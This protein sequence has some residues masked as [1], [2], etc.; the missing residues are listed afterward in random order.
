MK[1]VIDL[2]EDI[3]ESIANDERYEVAVGLFKRDPDGSQKLVYA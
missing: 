1:V 2:I 3:R